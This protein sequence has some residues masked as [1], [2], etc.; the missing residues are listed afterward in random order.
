MSYAVFEN[1]KQISK[2]YPHK[3]QAIINAFELGL[4]WRYGLEY[5]LLG[6][7]IVR[8]VRDEK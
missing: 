5:R 3:L 4:V 6:S 1:N 2:V 7:T 8:E